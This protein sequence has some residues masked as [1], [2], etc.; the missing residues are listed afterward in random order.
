MNT[1]KK[2]MILI[3]IHKDSNIKFIFYIKYKDISLYKSIYSYT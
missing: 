3:L 2:Y 1:N